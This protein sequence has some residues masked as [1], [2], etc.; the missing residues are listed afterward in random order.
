MPK[1]KQ[2]HG[3][4]AGVLW[5][6]RDGRH[7]AMAVDRKGLLCDHGGKAEVGETPFQTARRESREEA[8][9]APTD[10]DC[11]GEVQVRDGACVVF[12]CKLPAGVD[13]RSLKPSAGETSITGTRLVSERLNDMQ[14]KKPQMLGNRLQFAYG[15]DLL[16]LQKLWDHVREES[17]TGED[18]GRKCSRDGMPF[19]MGN[20]GSNMTIRPRHGTAEDGEGSEAA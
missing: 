9:I 20:C 15:R 7:A 16:E 6:T 5:I 2:S 10:A 14:R 17:G 13:P 3:P 1:R 12:V 8:G 18:K 4:S 19:I 11:I